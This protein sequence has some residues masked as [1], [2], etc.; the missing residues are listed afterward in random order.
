[1][2]VHPSKTEPTLLKLPKDILL[3]HIFFFSVK[4]H[5]KTIGALKQTSKTFNAFFNEE[6]LKNIEE[7]KKKNYYFKDK[8]LKLL[9]KYLDLPNTFY[10]MNYLQFQTLENIFKNT[11][12]NDSET[13]NILFHLV[14]L[15]LYQTSK[16]LL[17]NNFVT[18]LEEIF[19]TELKT[20][21]QFAK[22]CPDS[23]KACENNLKYAHTQINLA[24]FNESLFLK[25]LA[26]M[27]EKE[28]VTLAPR[29]RSLRAGE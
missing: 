26:N 28:N 9:H 27:I 16:K 6:P 8:L 13:N 3:H 1:M 20:S 17:E 12:I 23:F 11:S 25:D 24:A 29:P 15:F 18:S 14:F 5:P 22:I 7:N 21:E 4:N 19:E 10:K 2:I